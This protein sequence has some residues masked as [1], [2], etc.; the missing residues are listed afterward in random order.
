MKRTIS[1]EVVSQIGKEV[2]VKGWLHSL[3]LLGKVNF[4]VLRDRGGF[5]QIVVEDKNELEK[6]KDLQPGSILEITGKV[7]EAKQ[8]ELGVEIIKP[9][10]IV[11]VGVEESWP[12]EVNKPEIRANLDTVLDFRPLTLRNERIQAVFKIQATILEAYREFLIENGFTEFMGPSIISASSEGGAEL[13]NVDYFGYDAKLA[14]SNQLYKQMMVGV[15]ERVFGSLKCFRAENSN[16]SRHITEATQ[17]EF[18]IGFIEGLDEI[19]DWEEK[20]IRAILKKVNEKNVRELK[21]FENVAGLPDDA[22]IPRMTLQEAL[23]LY[24]KETGKDERKEPDLSPEAERFLCKYTKEKYGVDFI[25]VTHF[26]RKKCAFYAKPSKE[27]PEVCNYGDLLCNGAEVSSGGQRID[28]ANELKES[29]VL[30][31]L[32]PVDFKDYLSIFEYGMPRHGGFGLGLERF[33]QQLLGLTNI[34]EAVLF[35]SDTKRI[36][37]VPINRGFKSGEEIVGTIR[38]LLDEKKLSY[39]FFE[40]EA[41]V[42]SEDA[43]KV[44]GTKPGEGVKALILKSKGSDKNILVC[45]PGNRKINFQH[46]KEVTGEKFTF[47][48][49]EEI[50]KKWG[51]EVGGVP[52]FGNLLG[53]DTIYDEDVEKEEYSSFNC[54]TKFKSIRMKSKDLIDLVDPKVV[55]VT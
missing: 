9:N 23:E 34:R 20:V 31:E 54:G 18:E 14:Q 2:L 53:L 44:R 33:T 11:E 17:L 12:V 19:L 51:L 21:M 49:P 48:D 1:K 41:T 43:A 3:R 13:F 47:E 6:I 32:N 29:L 46:L 5:I 25:F 10:I 27:N 37:S 45:L 42:T 30:K 55:D 35:P 50:K 52:P 38:K 4:L 40:H 16:T 26:P 22:R 15:N 39:E 28:K 24:F 8:T 36:A 7:Q